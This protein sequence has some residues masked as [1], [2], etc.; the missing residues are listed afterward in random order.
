MQSSLLRLGE[1][2]KNQIPIR[3]RASRMLSLSLFLPKR[4]I[5]SAQNCSSLIDQMQN[6]A[7][8]VTRSARFAKCL[9][10]FP[11]QHARARSSSNVDSPLS[12]P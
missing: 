10:T 1:E 7:R 9:L 4:E 8:C 6:F 5:S 2:G 3:S 11:L 12:L